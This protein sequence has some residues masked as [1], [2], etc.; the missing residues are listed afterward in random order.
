MNLY[1]IGYRGSGKST[2]A[3][4]L[5]NLIGCDWFDTDELITTNARKSITQIFADHGEAQFRRLETQAITTTSQSSSPNTHQVISL[6]GGAITIS[7]NQAIVREHGL[8]VYLR[9]TADTLWQRISTDPISGQQR[10]N[11]TE[12]GGRAEVEQVLAARRSIY[13]T[14]SDFQIDIDHITA[15]Q[16]AEQIFGWWQTKVPPQAPPSQATN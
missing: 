16:A 8:A 13:Q 3:P 11:L 9:G 1:L 15:D 12:H 6:G 2:I 14:H 10:P 5:A 4:R 7:A